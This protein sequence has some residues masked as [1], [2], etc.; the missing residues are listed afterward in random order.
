MSECPFTERI[1]IYYDGELAA[2]EAEAMEQHI[3]Q[4]AAC[5]AELERLRKLSQLMRRIAVPVEHETMMRLHRRLDTTRRNQ[6]MQRF[7]E[8][9]T[10]LAASVLIICGAILMAERVPV[11]NT[12]SMP[13][14]ESALLAPLGN[15][16][17]ANNLEENVAQWMVQDLSRNNGNE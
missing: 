4:C 7:A 10:A 16:Q 6:S 8:I 9:C 12:A 1:G 3:E 11:V 17:M 13:V 14:W 5:G 15:E 2:R